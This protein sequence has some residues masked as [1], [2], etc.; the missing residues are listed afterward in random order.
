MPLTSADRTSLEQRR[1]QYRWHALVLG[2]TCFTRVAQGETVGTLPPS[3]GTL[4][5]AAI[6][7][8]EPTA[9]LPPHLLS[10]IALV[11]SGRQIG[12]TIAPWPWTINVNGVGRMF[13]T[14]EQAV[15]AVQEAQQAGMPSV[16]VGCMQINLFYHPHAFASLDDAFDPAS[17]V[18]YAVRFLGDLHQ[19]TGD[20]GTA[21]ADYHSATPELGT[22]Y[23][24]RVA[25][26][27]PG[28]PQFR[29]SAA[30]RT[31]ALTA[32]TLAA[33]VDPNNTL[34]PAF[35]AQ[36]IEAAAFR[37]RQKASA[38]DVRPTAGP[39]RSG[40]ALGSGQL[41]GQRQAGLTTRALEDEVDPKRVLT[42]EFRAQMVAAA[43]LRR[44]HD[45]ALGAD[46]V[47]TRGP[48]SPARR[49]TGSLLA[50][51]ANR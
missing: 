9:R 25:A 37:H 42:P 51:Y 48:E 47:G 6:A 13:D 29:L 10:A 4:C 27:W 43:A 3:A 39:A 2:I 7:A 40:P 26:L 1:R 28:G 5:T 11:E 12:G 45:A 17:N 34:T 49:S 19:Q 32:A 15:A 18:A 38:T 20:W 24:Q 8:A 41:R 21:I 22:A 50:L 36:M 35:R 30:T 14:K 31:M 23:A 16:D 33:E 44:Q 46:R